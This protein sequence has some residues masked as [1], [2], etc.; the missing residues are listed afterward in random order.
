MKLPPEY[1][2][3]RAYPV[4][5]VL[6]HPSVDAEQAL[7]SLACEADRNGYILIAPD[8]AG[9]FGKG[10]QWKGDDHVYVTA[11]LRDA[12]RHFC[13]DND[14]VF[15]FGAADGANMA[16]D[17]GMSHPDLFAGVLAMGPIPKWQNMF[18]EYWR[19]A[20]KLPFYCVTGEMSGDSAANLR[21]IFGE[22]MPRG[23]P[24]L[25]VVYKGR[26]IEWYGSEMPVMFDWMGR[27]KRVSGTA[28]LALG[29]NARQPW[30]TMRPTDNRFYWIGVDSIRARG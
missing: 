23:F 6:T 10:W 3:G 9:Q 28:T 1:H 14:R 20:Q 21:K 7:G 24:G 26:G 25:M 2:H 4:L 13:V 27:K 5:I 29:N 16:M 15:L 8:W 11:V 12:I 30:T 18:M 17:V 22:W 19:N